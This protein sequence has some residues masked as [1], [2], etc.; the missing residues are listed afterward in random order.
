[1]DKYKKLRQ[2][3]LEN[4]ETT[5]SKKDRLHTQDILNILSNNKLLFSTGKTAQV[6]KSMNIGQHTSDCRINS[7]SKS[8][9]YYIAYKGKK[10]C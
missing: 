10:S 5:T 6:F 2:F 9:Y 4:F 7:V 8:G 1:M 3:I